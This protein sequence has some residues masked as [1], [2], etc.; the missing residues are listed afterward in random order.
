MGINMHTHNKFW[1]WV[2]QS[3]QPNYQKEIEQYLSEATDRFD[4]EYRMRLLT[5]RGL[6]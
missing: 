5:R 2:K 1:E 4:L 3:F 6:I